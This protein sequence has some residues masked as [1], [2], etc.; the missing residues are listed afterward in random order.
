M[1][2]MEMFRLKQVAANIK[3]CKR[4]LSKKPAQFHFITQIAR[5]NMKNNE[6]YG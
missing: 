1:K 4:R 6:K 2:T 3:R 5:R